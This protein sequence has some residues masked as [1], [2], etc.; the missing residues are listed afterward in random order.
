LQIGQ[1]GKVIAPDLYIGVGISGAIQHLAGIKDAKTIVAINNNPEAEIFNVR[2]DNVAMRLT[3][4]HEAYVPSVTSMPGLCCSYGVSL[5]C[6]MWCI[7][8]LN[9]AT[10]CAFLYDTSMLASMIYL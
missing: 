6:T 9:Y 10:A 3:F 2:G 1:T 5:A 4:L 8:G 7:Y